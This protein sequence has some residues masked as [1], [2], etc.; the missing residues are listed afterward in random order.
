[1]TA[2]DLHPSDTMPDGWAQR[3]ATTHAVFSS[4]RA[5]RYML[6]RHR[7]G[8]LMDWAL[9][10]AHRLK[11]RRLYVMLNPS[12]AGEQIDGCGVDDM[13]VK[14]CGG[15]LQGTS[16]GQFVIVNLFAAV[17]THPLDLADM[18]DPVGPAND[19]ALQ[20]GFDWMM[21][22]PTSSLVLAWGESPFRGIEMTRRHADQVDK[23]WSLAQRYGIRPT[24][25][26]LTKSKAPAHPSRLAYGCSPAGPLPGAS[27]VVEA[28]P[29]H[30]RPKPWPPAS[31]WPPAP[32]AGVDG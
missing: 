22:A 12:D 14:K 5:Y 2:P 3:L 29:W 30:S 25:L 21:D 26:S 7:A 15:F 8:G 11:G 32:A 13:T 19:A 31:G 9:N 28:P 24:A 27:D 16:M 10:D 23:V 6:H 18:A 17:A 1:M 4:D 20:F